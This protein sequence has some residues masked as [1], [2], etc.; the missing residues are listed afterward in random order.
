MKSSSMVFSGLL[1]WTLASLVGCVV[2]TEADDDS[3]YAEGDDVHA[4]A[5]EDEQVGEAEGA[6]VGSRGDYYYTI[7]PGEGIWGT[8]RQDIYCNPGSWAIGYT[9]RVERDQGTRDDDTALNSVRLLCQDARG[10]TIEW[11]SSYDGLWGDWGNAASCSGAANF[12]TS[13]QL[14]VEGSRGGRR[15][16]TAANDVKFGCRNGGTAY[17]TNGG[18]WGGWRDWAYCPTGTAVC[19]LSIRFEDSQ[20]GGDDTAMNGLKLHCCSL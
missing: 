13:A 4:E 1:L 11:I 12:L 6:F 3:I 15:D 16:D 8:W 20:G 18:G 19:G 9:L 14:R 10:N 5:E 2:T 17:T 7:M